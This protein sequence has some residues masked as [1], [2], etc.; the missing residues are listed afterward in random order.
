[1]DHGALDDAL[2]RRRRPRVLPVGHHEAVEL[3]VDE[4]FEIALQ[5]LDVDIAAG[6][7][8]DGVAVVGEGQQKVFEG[9][10]LVGTLPGQ[11]H[12]LMQRLLKT[13]RK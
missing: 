12:G 13:A 6:E 11:V 10:E 9:S 5:R 4:I 8:G 2:E 1:M 7:H 3:F